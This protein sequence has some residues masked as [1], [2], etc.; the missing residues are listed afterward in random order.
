M[1]IAI[2]SKQPVRTQSA[3]YTFAAALLLAAIFAQTVTSIPRLSIT[4]DEDLHIAYGYSIWRTGEFQLV[5]EH[6]PLMQ[7]W[8][9]WPLVFSS[10]LPDPRQVPAWKSGDLKG[11]VRNRMWRSVPLD[12]WVIPCRIPISWLALLLGAF[13]FRWASDWFGPR[14]GF[15]A[16]GLL[17][18]D[19]NILANATVA[20][21]DL[22]T[23][24]FIFIAMYGLQ[25]LLRRPSRTNLIGAGFA[26]GLALAAKVSSAV[27]V[28]IGI[29]LMLLDG[30]RRWRQI[31]LAR[32]AVYLGI[33]FLTVW[34]VH[35]FEFGVPPKL[36]LPARSPD[37][38]QSQ[39][40]RE[41]TTIVQIPFPL[42]AQHFLHPFAMVIRHAAKGNL[43]YLL[44]ETYQW[45]RWYFFPVVFALK[46]PLPTLILVAIALLVALRRPQSRWRELILA[47]L[48]VSYLATSIFSPINLGYRHLLPI[49]PFLYLF[50]A[51]LAEPWRKD[52]LVTKS[53]PF[54]PSLKRL[55]TVALVILVIWQ[56]VGTVLTWPFYLTFFNESVGGSRNGYRYLADSNVDW[57]QGL[58]ALRVYLEE[59]GW[60]NAQTKVSS[61]TYF[62]RPDLYGILATPLPPL[63]NAPAMLPSHF[64]PAPG[65]YVI[66][67]ST[68]RGRQVQYVDVEMYNWFWHREPDDNLAGSMHCAHHAAGARAD[69]RRVWSNRP[70]PD[71]F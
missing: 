25:R 53:L 2:S 10:Q 13:L 9:S 19:P 66:S 12:S 30:L 16:L 15:L 68:L 58:K 59:R 48:P 35:R 62:I 61:F 69:C 36:E 57:G 44:G 21:T 43:T 26:L 37:Q 28:P 20:T 46:T 29:G 22:G 32:M 11:F 40:D 14:A 24:C 4:W 1:K 47:S 71:W 52:Q 23:T 45:G 54:S 60:N 50:V 38:W 7:T 5:E 49:V 51:R 6:P 42:P 41:L 31:P 65:T 8:M 56:V 67:A 18:F 33:A 70:A 27:L 63:A 64:N 55:A 39:E 17:A 3:L 34:A